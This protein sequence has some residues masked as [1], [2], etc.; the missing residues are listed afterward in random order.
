MELT[1]EPFSRIA[2]ILPRQRG[3]VRISNLQRLNALLYVASNGCKWRSLP[4]RYGRWHTVYM[5]QHHGEVTFTLLMDDDAC[6][7]DATRA[8]AQAFDTR[9]TA[10]PAPQTALAV[11]QNAE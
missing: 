3:N 5:R 9:C 1:E 6:Q 4:E 2:P 7:D 8:L 10:Q 11:R